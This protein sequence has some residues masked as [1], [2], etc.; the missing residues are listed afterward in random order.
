MNS[1]VAPTAN[2][3]SATASERPTQRCGG[4]LIRR[5][6]LVTTIAW[7]RATRRRATCGDLASL[8]PRR[9]P[10]RRGLPAQSHDRSKP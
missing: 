1:T 4:R 5:L 3:T 8:L 2:I 6:R 7:A 9:S 10:E